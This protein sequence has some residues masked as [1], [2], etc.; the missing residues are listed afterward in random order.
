MLI[1]VALLPWVPCLLE[2]HGV[3][4]LWWPLSSPLESDQ[5]MG[6]E[7]SVSLPVWGRDT[8][9]GT[10]KSETHEQPAPVRLKAGGNH[11]LGL[12]ITCFD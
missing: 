2:S 11:H 7:H 9:P 4:E 8:F 3:P 6:S 10:A 1:K 12:L 5:V